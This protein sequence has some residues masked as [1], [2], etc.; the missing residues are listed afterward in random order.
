[1]QDRSGGCGRLRRRRAP[2]RA[3][4]EPRPAV[5]PVRRDHPG[6]R[7]PSLEPP[8]V[9]PA[10]R[11]DPALGGRLAAQ[12]HRR[13]RQDEGQARRRSSAR[14]RS[15]SPSSA[16][17][18]ASRAAARHPEAFFR[19][20]RDGG[21]AVTAVPAD[22]WQL[23][24]SDEATP[25]RSG[26]RRGGAGSCASRSTAS[27]RPSSASRR[28]RRR[29]LDPQQRLLLEVAWEAL[30]DAGQAP[31][32]ARREHD[33]RLRRRCRRTTT[34]DAVHGPPTRRRRTS[35]PRTGNGPSVRRRAAV[36]HARAP[37]AERRGGHGVLVVAG[38]GA[39]CL[40]EPAQ[41]RVRRWPSPA[42]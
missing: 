39:P 11:L 21:D 35:T 7:M 41:R 5:Q 9:D 13:A 22:R 6:R 34:L 29:S 36:V 28:A 42:G 37:G 19:F 1:M 20:L 8:I 2:T 38:G 3:R 23:D 18:A 17:P 30:E 31:A 15:P 4:I 25:T 14:R 40:P 10:A 16:W 26:A 12:G 27:T 33:G 32:S 24:L